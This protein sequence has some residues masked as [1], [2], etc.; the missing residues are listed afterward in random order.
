MNL[1]KITQLDDDTEDRSDNSSVLN[2]VLDEIDDDL[3][4]PSQFIDIP[5][6]N[7]NYD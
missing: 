1:P 2:P 4:D 3:E 6:F 7:M 5:K